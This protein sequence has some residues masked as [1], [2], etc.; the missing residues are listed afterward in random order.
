MGIFEKNFFLH[1]VEDDEPGVD[2]PQ[3][4]GENTGGVAAGLLWQVG[5]A[6][7]VGQQFVEKGFHQGK[8]TAR[9]KETSWRFFPW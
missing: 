9:Q 5:S 6:V 4:I 3:N 2:I 7:P 1:G 8:H